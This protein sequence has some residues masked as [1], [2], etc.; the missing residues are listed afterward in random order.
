MSHVE[1]ELIDVFPQQADRIRELKAADAHFA[2]L[3]DDYS[4]LNRRI[5]RIE[6]RGTDRSGALMQELKA[7]RLAL[8]DAIGA[9]LKN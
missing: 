8:L 7:K 9:M 1:H 4:D 6:A 5:H 2:R 3:F